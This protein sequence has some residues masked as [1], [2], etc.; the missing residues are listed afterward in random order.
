MSCASERRVSI[1]KWSTNHQEP[2]VRNKV[3]GALG[4]KSGWFITKLPFCLA[5]ELTLKVSSKGE[6]ILE[7]WKFAWDEYGFPS[8]QVWRWWNSDLLETSSPLFIPV[9]LGLGLTRSLEHLVHSKFLYPDRM[10]SRG[11]IR[12]R[13]EAINVGRFPGQEGQRGEIEGWASVLRT[14]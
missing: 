9:K 7:Q 10:E 5:P 1:W 2:M 8:W 13:R 12:T 4:W 6:I 11:V 14:C 3:E